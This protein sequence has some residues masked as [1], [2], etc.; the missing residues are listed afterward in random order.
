[1]AEDTRKFG[2]NHSY[3]LSP[4]RRL[5]IEQSLD[6]H[7]EYEGIAGCPHIVAP[8]RQGNHLVV[9]LVLAGLLEAAVKIS[10]VGGHVDDYFAIQFHDGAEDPV[11]TGM[12]W[13][14]VEF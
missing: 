11:R 6:S 3:G 7:A 9:V 13:P 5:H 8:F 4:F 12:M 14:Q 1:M 2:H 10:K